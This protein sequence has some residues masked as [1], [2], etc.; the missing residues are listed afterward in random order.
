MKKISKFF[1]VLILALLVSTIAC[2][3]INTTSA[4]AYGELKI[5]QVGDTRDYGGGSY[6]KGKMKDATT[7]NTVNTNVAALTYKV[8][9]AT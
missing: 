5:T 6:G 9:I 2:M 8:Y 3:N 7:Y 4:Y 1:G